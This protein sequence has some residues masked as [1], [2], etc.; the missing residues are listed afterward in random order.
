[1]QLAA[2]GIAEVIIRL[3]P[4]ASLM[5]NAPPSIARGGACLAKP[6]HRAAHIG[7]GQRG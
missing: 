1:V 4:P 6:R 5:R 3:A 7:S 2:L